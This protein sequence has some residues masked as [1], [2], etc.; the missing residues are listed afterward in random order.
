MV[1]TCI[2]TYMTSQSVGLVFISLMLA[3]MVGQFHPG[4]YIVVT[5]K[6]GYTLLM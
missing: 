3:Y 2:Y 5:G 1:D 6:V 4:L